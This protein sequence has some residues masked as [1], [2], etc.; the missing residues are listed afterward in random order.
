MS[1]IYKDHIHTY[2]RS[3]SNKE[4][5]RCISKNCTHYQ[6]REFLRDKE[7]LCNNCREPFILTWEQLKNKRPVCLKCSKSN[8][9]KQVRSVAD[10]IADLFPV[11]VATLAPE[12]L[13][14]V[15]PEEPRMEWE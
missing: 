1:K 7:A 11:S 5:Y 12:A 8:K 9:A 15:K 2:E 10:Q 14:E 4:V 6:R 3:L 13:P